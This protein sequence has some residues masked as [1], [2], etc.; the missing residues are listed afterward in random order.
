MRWACADRVGLRTSDVAASVRQ[1]QVRNPPYALVTTPESLA[2]AFSHPWGREFVAGVHSIVVDEWHEFMGSKR[3]VLLEL[4]LAEL[5]TSPASPAIWGLSATL[6]N[7]HEGMH[8]LLGETA[9]RGRLITG[10]ADRPTEILSVRPS[11]VEKFSWAGHLGLRLVDEV[12]DLLSDSQPT[13]L[14][15]NTRSQAELWFEAL[16]RA[17]PQW[18]GEIAIHHGSI[19][20]ALRSEIEDGLG[21]GRWRCVVCTSSLDLGVDFAPVERVIQIG[22]AKGVARLLQRAGRSAHRPGGTARIHCVPTQALGLLEIAAARRAAGDG[23][24]EPRRPLRRC[25]DVLSQH[26]VTMACGPGFRVDEQLASVRSTAAFEDLS[27]AEWEWCPRLYRARRSGAQ[28]LCAFSPRRARRHAARR[29]RREACTPA[30][31]ADRHDR[32]RRYGPGQVSS[33]VNQSDKSRNA[34]SRN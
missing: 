32:I 27:D 21:T 1:R 30:S 17:R 7:T 33:P 12:V 10:P 2:V 20:K 28:G 11:R 13:L 25:L 3:G 6:G 16:L 29:T 24:I 9:N 19:A 26:L 14:F 4:L 18:L 22:S 5:R 23:V 34:S 31:T 15:T 8:T